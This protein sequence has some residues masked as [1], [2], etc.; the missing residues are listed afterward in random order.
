ML[1][2]IAAFSARHESFAF[3]TTLSGLGYLRHMRAWRSAGHHASLIFWPCRPLKWPLHVWP[4][5]CAK[6]DMTQNQ[7]SQAKDKPVR[8][9]AEELRKNG[10]E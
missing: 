2:E 1:E 8:I 4:S 6:A 3:E 7:L 5:G 9:T 10:A